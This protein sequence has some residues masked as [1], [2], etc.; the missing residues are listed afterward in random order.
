MLGRCF[1]WRLDWRLGW[2]PTRQADAVNEVEARLAHF[3]YIWNALSVLFLVTH[4]ART[5][6]EIV[7]A[8]AAR[9]SHRVLWAD[10]VA[11][12]DWCSRWRLR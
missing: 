9:D 12:V 11:K 2:A 5:I 6:I 7:V 3:L 1:R 4:D 8:S 10:I